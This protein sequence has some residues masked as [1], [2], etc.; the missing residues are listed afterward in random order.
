MVY[1]AISRYGLYGRAMTKTCKVCGVTDESAE[2]YAGVNNRCKE[3]HKMLVRQNR[4]EKAEYYRAYDAERYQND[5]RVKE[6]HRRY[7]GTKAGKAATLRARKKWLAKAPEKRA[8]HIILGNA[9]RDG[10]VNKPANCSIC[11]E[12]G[13]IHGHHED[14]TKPLDVIWCCAHCHKQFHK[15]N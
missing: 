12:T 15:E 6:R 7:R 2:F 8:A 11:G 14:Y 1:L 5:S 13:R 9:V 4:E 10:I 3:C